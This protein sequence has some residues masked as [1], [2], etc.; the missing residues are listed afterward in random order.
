MYNSIVPNPL[1]TIPISFINQGD[2]DG[3]GI[4]GFQ[5][6]S[7]GLE[8]ISITSQPASTTVGGG[9]PFSFSVGVS[10]SGPRTI[11]WYS[12]NVAIPGANALSYSGTATLAMDGTV[13]HVTIANGI[14]SSAQS[15]DATL[16]VAAV[17]VLISAGSLDSLTSVCLRF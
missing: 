3:I 13:F 9:T 12:N 15:A 1:H 5:L 6:L 8:P 2:P 4:A 17:P 7:T 11:Q 16:S 10:G 14:P